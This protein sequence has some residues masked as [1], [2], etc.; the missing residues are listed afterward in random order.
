MLTYISWSVASLGNID[1]QC[2]DKFLSFV[3]SPALTVSLDNID[4]LCLDK[5]LSFVISPALTVF[6]CAVSASISAT[7]RRS[8]SWFVPRFRHDNSVAVVLLGNGGLTCYKAFPPH[9]TET[10]GRRLDA[11]VGVRTRDP[12]KPSGNEAVSQM[13]QLG[14]QAAA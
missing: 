11:E 9:A 6:I 1:S 2:L 5:C 12:S 4:S 13:R 14:D 7:A 3:I 8:S 10:S